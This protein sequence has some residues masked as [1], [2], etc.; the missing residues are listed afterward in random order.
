MEV[1]V[2][3]LLAIALSALLAFAPDGVSTKPQQL[4]AAEARDLLTSPLRHVRALDPVLEAA[5]ASGVERSA[6]I[7]ALL[8]ALQDTDVIV[9]IVS[10][11]A[12]PLSTP[13]RLRLVPD[14][15]QF[16]FLRIDVRLEG[17]EDDLIMIL[18]HELQ[19]ALEIAG[20]PEV[21]DDRALIRLYE[22]IGHRDG[23]YQFD[24]EAAHAASRQIRK[25]LYT[26]DAQARS[27]YR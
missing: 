4:S 25:E 22:R 13:A 8:A 10:S 2:P 12:M 6:T 15:R 14:P 5:L 21:R 17:S 20:A 3:H 26:A 16:R 19:H 9:Q 7:G 1:L 23:E 24:S 11:S 27:T 18:G